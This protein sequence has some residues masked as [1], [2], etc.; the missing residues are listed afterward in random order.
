MSF[1]ENIKKLR[2]EN[3]LTQKELAEKLNITRP[4]VGRYELDER[5]PDKDLIIKIADIFNVSLDSLFGREFNN[6]EAKHSIKVN[7]EKEYLSKII[8]E[9]NISKEFL[10]DDEFLKDISKY[11]IE[12]ALKIKNLRSK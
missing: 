9:N 3:N 1:G 7:V 2:I 6:K 12:A 11:G 8:G 4:T 5:F 10:K